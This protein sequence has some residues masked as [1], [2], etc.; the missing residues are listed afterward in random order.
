MTLY[1]RSIGYNSH[2]DLALAVQ[3]VPKMKIYWHYDMV[4]SLP[5]EERLVNGADF[6]GHVG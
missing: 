5:K 2:N 4:E 6:N 1:P 3:L